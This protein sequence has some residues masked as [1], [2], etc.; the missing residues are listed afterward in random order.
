MLLFILFVDVVVVVD[1]TILHYSKG[2]WVTIVK[3]G[4]MSIKAGLRVTIL[5]VHLVAIKMQVVTNFSRRIRNRDTLLN[6]FGS[7]K[8]MALW[9]SS[10]LSISAIHM[11]CRMIFILVFAHNCFRLSMETLYPNDKQKLDLSKRIGLEKNH[12]TYWFQNRRTQ[13]KVNWTTLVFV[14]VFMNLFVDVLNGFFP[15]IRCNGNVM[16]TRFLDRKMRSFR[17][18]IIC[19]RRPWKMQDA[20]IVVGA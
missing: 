11:F 18:R 1:G 16:G 4:T 12:V 5:K 15:W 14:L 7:L 13:W 20:I 2:K 8:R 19:W 10:F 17:L 3:Q 9:N 6:N